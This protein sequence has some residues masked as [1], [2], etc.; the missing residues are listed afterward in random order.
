MSCR[1]TSNAYI[2][3]ILSCG[4]C[5]L[6]MVIILFANEYLLFS[7]VV[8]YCS[9]SIFPQ[10]FNLLLYPFFMCKFVNVDL[11]IGSLRA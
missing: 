7:A 9:A 10:L 8:H 2:K 4:T 3:R 11:L 6:M 1:P 5:F